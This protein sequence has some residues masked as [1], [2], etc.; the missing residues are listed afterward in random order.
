MKSAV[1]YD[2]PNLPIFV[3]VSVYDTKTV[4]FLS[5]CCKSIKLV[6]ET[7]QLDYPETQMVRDAHFLHLNVNDSYYHNM[8][9]V[10]PSYQLQN[11]YQFDH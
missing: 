6:K 8:N 11:V 4:H 3:A 1:L 2:F 9:S 10:E 7:L 5:M